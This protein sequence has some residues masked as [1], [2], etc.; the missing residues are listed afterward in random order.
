[1]LCNYGCG[2][3][4]KYQFKNGKWCCSRNHQSCIVLRKNNSKA[5]NRVMKEVQNREQVKE[6]H[7]KATKEVWKNLELKEKMSI[8]IKEALSRPEVREKKSKSGR[9]AWKNIEVRK[10]IIDASKEAK[11]KPEV[12]RRLIIAAK[13][14][15][16]SQTEKQKEEHLSKI[17]KSNEIKPNKTELLLNDILQNIRSNEFKYVGDGQVWI[18][19][20][21]P[22]WI[23]INGKK[24]VIEYFSNYWHGKEIT[25]REKENE[26]VFRREHFKKYGFDCLVIWEGELKDIDLLLEKIKNF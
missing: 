13:K 18:A 16:Y 9:E 25:G 15:W 17:F 26:E 4:A 7:S 3:E 2:Q 24:Q 20:K 12:K 14:V 11:K 19:G 6:N 5:L 1:M 21:C 10:R 8:S 22:D 23:N